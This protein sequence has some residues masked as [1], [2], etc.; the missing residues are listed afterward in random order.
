MAT[1]MILVVQMVIGSLSLFNQAPSGDEM[2]GMTHGVPMVMEHLITAAQRKAAAVRA[3]AARHSAELLSASA[4][5]N[6]ASLAETAVAP[7]AAH[8]QT[9]PDP[10]VPDY[11]GPSPNYANSPLP[12]NVLITPGVGD[13]TGTGAEAIATVQTVVGPGGVVTRGVVTA[14]KVI[15]PGTGY[16]TAPTITVDTT[17]SMVTTSPGDGTGATSEATVANGQIT[18]IKVT[19]GGQNYGGIR[20]FVD[21]LPGLTAA[22]ANTFGQY[23]QLAAPDKT[24]YPG[25]DYY[26]IGLVEYQQQFHRDLPATKLRGYVQLN[27]PATQYQVTRD[28]SGK[29]TGWPQPHYL[30]PTIVAQRDVPVRIKFVNLLPTGTGGDLF[31]PMDPTVMGAGDGPQAVMA[32]PEVTATDALGNTI[33]EPYTQN[34]ATLHLHG[35]LTPWISDGTPHQWTTPAGEPT[36]YP[37][38]VSTQNV[39]DMP[40]AGPGEMTFFYSNQQSAR[41][42]FYHDHAYGI[43]RLNV[44]AGEAAGYLLQDKFE[45]TLVAGGVIT[46]TNGTSITID[47]VVPADQIPL[48]IQ[49]KTFVPGPNQLAVQDPTWDHIWRT[50]GP[51]ATQ[52]PSLGALWMPHVYM[53]NQ[54]PADLS[55]TNAMGRWDYS[56][57]F[58][59]PTTALHPTVTN[60]RYNPTQPSV[61]N[62][63]NPGIN[64]PSLTPEAFMDTPIVNGVA[65]PYLPVQQKIYRFRILNAAN[66]RSLNLQLYF[67][68]SN[69]QMWDAQGN[70]N[71]PNAGEPNM[72][73]AI[74]PALP[75]GMIPPWPNDNRLGGVPDQKT[76]GP[77]WIQIGTE[78]GFLPAPVVVAPRP[79]GYENNLRNIVVTNINAHSLMLA[80]AER[81]DVIVD[82]SKVPAGSKLILYNDSPAPVPAF[83]PRYDYYTHDWNQ[84]DSGGAPTTLAGYG[85]NT[86]TIMQIQVT[87]T[88]TNPTGLRYDQDI[89]PGGRIDKLKTA[90]QATFEAS[91]DPIIVPEPAYNGVYGKNFT[92]VSAR[93]QNMSLSFTPNIAGSTPVTVSLQPKAIQE[94]FELEYGRMNA[95]MGVEI[96][97]TTGANQTTIP[98]GYIDPATE[99]IND[100]VTAAAPQMGTSLGTLGDGTQIWKVTHNGVDTHAIHFHLFNVQII[101]RVGWDGQV[102]LP[103]ANE[104]GWKD[105]VRMNPLEDA[106]VAL[107]PIAAKTPFGTYQSIRRLDVTRPLGSTKDFW[108]QLP[109]GQP[110]TTINALYN[111]GDEYVWHCHLLGHEENDMM[112]PIVFNTTR[113]PP[114]LAG[115]VAAANLASG[116]VQITWP[117]ATPLH[118]T[119]TTDAHGVQ[120]TTPLID[121]T[122][123]NPEGEIGYR[124]NRVN[125]DGST[126]IF[127]TTANTTVFTDSAITAGTTYTY[128][129]S[130][131][132]DA[133]RSAATVGGNEASVTSDPVTVTAGAV[134]APSAPTVLVSSFFTPSLGVNLT[135]ANATGHVDSYTVERS[136]D[137]TAGSWTPLPITQPFTDTAFTDAAVTANTTYFYHVIASNTVGSATSAPLTV[138]TLS[139]APTGLSFVASPTAVT[140]SWTALGGTLTG[141][142]VERS[143]DLISWQ[144]IS[145][146]A[147]LDPSYIDNSVRSNASYFYHVRANNT[148]G[149]S[150]A[151]DAL[152][153]AVKANLPPAPINLNAILDA[154]TP[155][156]VSLT[157]QSGNADIPVTSYLIERST[158]VD[159]P[160][161]RVGSSTIA[162]FTDTGSVAPLTANTSYYYHVI[163]TNSAYAPSYDPNNSI[164]AS[165]HVITLPGAPTNLTGGMNTSGWVDLSW[166]APTGGADS[167]TVQ[168]NDGTGVTDLITV[169]AVAPALTAPTVYSDTNITANTTYTYTVVANNVTPA[170]GLPSNSA[171]VVV[172][173]TA[174]NMVTDLAAT[175]TPTGVDLK[176]IAPTSVVTRYE[177]GQRESANGSVAATAW[178]TTTIPAPT[179]TYS[180]NTTTPNTQYDYQLVA[181]N[182]SGTGTASA[183]AIVLTLPSTPTM[184]PAIVDTTGVHLGWTIPGGNGVITGYTVQR[185]NTVGGTWATLASIPSTANPNYPDTGAVATF[186]LAANTSYD[187]QVIASNATGSGLGGD[188]RPSAFVSA[189]TVPGAPTGLNGAVNTTNGNIILGWSAPVGGDGT[190][191]GYTVQRRVTGTTGWDTL[192]TNL[193]NANYTDT[194]T[195]PNTLDS[196]TYYDYQVSASNASGPG[197]YAGTSAASNTS[198]L[199]L[200][201]S[202]TAASSLLTLPGATSIPNTSVV[203]TGVVVSW[204]PPTGLGTIRGYVVQRSTTGAPP[205]TL[206]N[207]AGTLLPT[208]V[209]TDT[210][211]TGLLPNTPYYYSVNAYNTTGVG[212]SSPVSSIITT[213]PAAPGVSVSF[214][215]GT[216]AGQ[217]QAVL[218]LTS[219]G[220]G[221]ITGYTIL[222]RTGTAGAFAAAPLTTINANTFVDTTNVV[223]STSVSYQVSATNTASGPVTAL[224]VRLLSTPAAPTGNGTTQQA[225]LTWKN[226]T[227][228]NTAT[229]FQLQRI[230]GIVATDWLTPTNIT[231]FITGT[232]TYTDKTVVP[233]TTYSYRLIASNTAGSSLPSAP[234]AVTVALPPTPTLSRSATTPTGSLVTAGSEAILNWIIPTGSIVSGFVVQRTTDNVWPGTTLATFTVGPT[235]RTYTD[236]PTKGANYYYR[237]ITVNGT[238]NGTPSTVLTVPVLT[239]PV[240]LTAAAGVTGSR[241]I[242]LTWTMPTAVINQTGFVLERST[243]NGGA[244]SQITVLGGTV[245]TYTNTGLKPKAT[246]LYRIRAI[247]NATGALTFN[248]TTTLASAIT[249]TTSAVTT[250]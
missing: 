179:T 189:L 70:L 77:S 36:S 99:S 153:V 176:W 1:T 187:Y 91:Q 230:T 156:Q 164:S 141:Y 132:N 109:N 42:M 63:V 75:M 227:G 5:S 139:D 178:I 122:W 236:T 62:P 135:W 129:V 22:G 221:V 92:Q 136:P 215:A 169:T 23:I 218:S 180:D 159:G 143:D 245:T 174:P 3:A 118:T 131:Y 208:P 209:F 20:K 102:R 184:Q 45:N 21:S 206:V 81:A 171:P 110:A 48:V 200:S 117:D 229:S 7:N 224:T 158:A 149:T 144:T 84:T 71:D 96:P 34:R 108:N 185:R 146:T 240:T 121:G 127:T 31:I 175:A 13:T 194:G 226:A 111:F 232:L 223:T 46:A 182:G 163:A 170:R 199:S 217:A 74:G 125:A 51:L 72:V 154:A 78:G 207:G 119:T 53:P 123:A 56:S 76:V 192:A 237:I 89:A 94:L 147:T 69:G 103:D 213:L 151:T 6:V 93:I 79:V 134:A 65:Y 250:P 142:T 173:P 17:I 30:G 193:N 12:P 126:A 235:L 26:E 167:Y 242:T 124:V 140:L 231:T 38:G 86:R 113:K 216:L 116:A 59:P 32:S 43:T 114:T 82:F 88:I 130:T 137:G 183:L 219:P 90:L 27:D 138:L 201:A 210:A 190:I 128:T 64:N 214:Q 29:I 195:A 14:I 249:S 100:S 248:A 211:A 40:P 24:T 67:A 11:F 191:T 197:L 244:W 177:L 181:V 150:A 239:A 25:S 37:K 157:W 28:A 50:G 238:A 222:R 44:Y 66:D 73:D 160:W 47:P 68:K 54:N 107:R 106:I 247:Y 234:V 198:G 120:T 112:R 205:W 95:T 9:A 202:T 19:S 41:L 145:T 97:Q 172:P 98:L 33:Y 203:P 4:L 225:V 162:A 188:G 105:T 52:P 104:L 15:N 80:P 155:T 58:W 16:T 85:P 196:N 61:E 18:G 243:N 115:P 186:P 35:G 168:R 241:V 133:R 60:P 233:G 8:A 212:P 204:N 57:W 148:T 2:A 55:G 165:Q 49:D 10:S 220:N 101:N 152:F 161:T 246:N 39:P 228:A 87:G 83:D 166:N